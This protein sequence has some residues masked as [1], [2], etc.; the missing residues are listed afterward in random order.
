[1]DISGSTPAQHPLG[2]V[3]S[4]TTISAAV[5]CLLLLIWLTARNPRTD[6]ATVF[7]NFIGI[8]PVVEGPVARL[9][10]R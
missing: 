9:A 2:K 3:L 1:M 5:L 6:D 8:A 4:I 7:A 10:V